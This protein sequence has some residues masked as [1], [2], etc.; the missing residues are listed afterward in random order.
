M[1]TMAP[2]LPCFI[3]CCISYFKHSQTPLMLM[4]ET[5]S[6][7]SSG[8]S[9][10]GIHLPSIP[11]LLKATSRRPNASTVFSTNILTS[12][13]LDTSPSRKSASPPAAR[14][15]LAVSLPSS[16]RRPVRTTFAPCCEKRI[17]VSRPMPEVPPVMR[18]TFPARSPFDCAA[19]FGLPDFPLR[20]RPFGSGS[21]LSEHVVNRQQQHRTRDRHQEAGLVALVIPAD[22]R[23][24]VGGHDRSRDSEQHGHDDSAG[25]APGHDQLG[26]RSGEQT[27]ESLPDPVHGSLHR[28]DWG[29]QERT[30]RALPVF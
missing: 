11:A 6:N 7:C 15:S 3:I 26:N 30:A 23:A 19:I 24:E 20:N 18:A 5:W 25:V 1:F 8:R 13:V 14:A 21:F 29:V 27:D 12:A 4:A 28:N 16:L 10:M 2:P 22:E 9:T 17:A